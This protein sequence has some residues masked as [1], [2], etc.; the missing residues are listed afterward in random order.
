MESI[1]DKIT[2][3]LKTMLVEGIILVSGCLSNVNQQVGE[4]A[5]QVGLTPA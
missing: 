1:L 2:E 5:D 3:W 4:I